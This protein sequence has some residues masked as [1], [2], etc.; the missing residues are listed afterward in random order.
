LSYNISA[1]VLTDNGATF[2]LVA[3]N[4][5]NSVS[6]S[7]TSSV[8]TLTVVADTN[9]P[10]LL[11]A[12]SAGLTQ[13]LVTFSERIKF[14]TA[15]NRANYSISGTNGGLLI[16]SASLDGSQSNAVLAVASMNDGAP[17]TLTVNNLSDQSAAANVIAPNSQAVFTASIYTPAAIGGP[18]PAGGQAAAGNGLNITAAARTWA[19]RA[20]NFSSATFR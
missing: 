14:G 10:V 11:G 16:N 17:Y 1:T 12:N 20:I 15:T 8:A 13:V 5:V 7:V 18:T 3:S 6:Y 9:R 19:E 4:M 2:R